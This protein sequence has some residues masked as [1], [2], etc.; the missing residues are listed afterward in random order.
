M[1]HDTQP[2]LPPCTLI[3]DRRALRAALPEASPGTEQAVWRVLVCIRLGFPE[4]DLAIIR[5][6]TGVPLLHYGQH[7]TNPG[8]TLSLGVWH[9]DARH[10]AGG[11][12]WIAEASD[13]YGQQGRTLTQAP[14][15]SRCV[16][17]L[18]KRVET[19]NRGALVRL[20]NVAR[21][22]TLMK[23]FSLTY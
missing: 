9:P 8:G 5:T 10:P 6:D 7:W 14:N 11:G 22:R 15:L 12:E 1:V 17:A 2:L 4:A 20:L 21:D 23:R 3:G 13:E 18:L 19:D 16:S